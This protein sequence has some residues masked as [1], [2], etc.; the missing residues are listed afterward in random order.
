MRIGW[1]WLRPTAWRS[2]A[3]RDAKLRDAR[4]RVEGIG[5]MRV[6]FETESRNEFSRSR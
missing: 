6:E 5:A 3:N 4:Q 1:T 2:G